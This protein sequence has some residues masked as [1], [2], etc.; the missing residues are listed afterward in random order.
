MGNFNRGGGGGRFDGNRRGGGFGGRDSGRG[1]NF[2]R[3]GGGGKSWDKPTVMHRTTCSNC[4]KSCEVPFRPTGAKPV[5]CNDCFSKNKGD[6]PSGN[7][8]KR[9]FERAP[10]SQSGAGDRR[11]DELKKQLELVNT[12]LD[13][14]L[15]AVEKPAR[16]KAPVKTSA[17]AP[18]SAK[19]STETEKTTLKKLVKKATTKAAKV[20]KK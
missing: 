14:L 18:V 6:A 3:G 16:V 19:K 8:S 12:K 10:S 4:G 5:Y 9:S 1:G 15:K 20:K 2:N 11:I 13:T 17:K 7:F